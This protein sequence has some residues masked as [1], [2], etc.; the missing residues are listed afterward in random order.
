MDK[1]VKEVL[2]E[3]REL[4]ARGF[5][6]GAMARDVR[7]RVCDPLDVNANCF[8]TLGALIRATALDYP[9]HEP[10]R[11]HLRKTIG[12]ST[13]VNHAEGTD[14]GTWNDSHTQEEVLAAFDKAIQEA[15]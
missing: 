5:T 9:V 1:T 15:P 4:L 8:C 2:T 10:A 3:A 7:G 14:T 11:V 12:L 6:Q 13:G